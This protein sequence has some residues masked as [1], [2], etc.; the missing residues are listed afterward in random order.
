MGS[1]NRPTSSMSGLLHVPRVRML[2]AYN[3]ALASG[4]RVWCRKCLSLSEK[5]QLRLIYLVGWATMREKEGVSPPQSRHPGGE[6]GVATRALPGT[7]SQ[8]CSAAS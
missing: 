8:P 4:V 1:G 6:V 2:G 7:L 5:A 3:W